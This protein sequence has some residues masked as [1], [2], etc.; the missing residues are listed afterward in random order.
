MRPN[1][2][3]RGSLFSLW[4]DEKNATSVKSRLFFGFDKKGE[5][6]SDRKSTFQPNAPRASSVEY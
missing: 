6:L 1:L 2:V 4:R 3:K 5:K